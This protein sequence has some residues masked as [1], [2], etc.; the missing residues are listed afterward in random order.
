MTLEQA[1]KRFGITSVWHFTDIENL[2]S[3]EEHNLSSL[4]VIE[5]EKIKV[6]HFGADDLSHELDKRRRL[7][8]YVHLAFTDDHPMY[9][10]AK[11]RGSIQKGIWLE[12]PIEEILKEDVLFC[13]G[14]ANENGAVL[15]SQDD[16]A[17]YID[18]DVLLHGH[19]FWKRV[20]A[21]KAEILVP[22]YI[23]F[24]KIIGAHYGK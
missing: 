19:D 21:R 13:D 12:I 20:E 2:P 4:A 3:I 5:K 7:D 10:V 8:K 9:H 22:N 6:P 16:I 15:R 23:E 14:V 11:S 18:F 1:L 24:N 17:D